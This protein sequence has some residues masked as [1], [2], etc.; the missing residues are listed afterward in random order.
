MN[1]EDGKCLLRAVQCCI[2]IPTVSVMDA[3]DIIQ[4]GLLTSSTLRRSST[5]RLEVA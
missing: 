5:P 2:W 1:G 3:E 4:V